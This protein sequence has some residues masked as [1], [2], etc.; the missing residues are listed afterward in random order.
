MKHTLMKNPTYILAHRHIC[1]YS[2]FHLNV[3][4]FCFIYG[5]PGSL[6]PPVLQV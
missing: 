6:G 4:I 1:A 5:S 3:V 2:W